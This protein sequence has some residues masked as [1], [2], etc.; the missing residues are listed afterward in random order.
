MQ[1]RIGL[2][3][4]FTTTLFSSACSED[5]TTAN[6][7]DGDEGSDEASN[8]DGQTGDD[9]DDVVTGSFDSGRRNDADSSVPKPPTDAS[10]SKDADDS[11]DEE[12]VESDGGSSPDASKPV[13]SGGSCLDGITDFGAKGPFK[14]AAKPSGRIKMWIPEVPA[15][16]KVP[17]IHLA[18]GTGA[19]CSSYQNVLNTLASHGFLTTC[20]E[21]TNTGAGSQ[22]LMALEAA[23]SMYPDLADK[24]F[25]TTGH[26][27]GGQAAFTVLA[28]AEEKF[29]AD[30]VYAG[31]AMQPASGFGDQPT[32][33]TWQQVYA[34]IKSPM[35][36][37][38]GT[39]DS[40]V[41]ASWVQRGFD[42]LDDG[43]EAYNWSARG[44]THIPTPQ[45]ETQEVA[46]PWFRWKLLGDQAA[47]QAFKALPGKGR[48]TE[49]KAQNAAECE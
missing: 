30:A 28:L 27:Q 22:G 8:D 39:S 34:K 12:A 16:C 24:R 21:D 23:V 35:F 43:I 41:S 1:I 2:V 3:C 17:V 26:S 19:S 38:S 40:L 31:L 10:S 45:A 32:G 6:P 42:A 36:A 49:V 11:V 15:G 48:W 13:T 33:G 44:S 47:C 18:N 46:V 14:Y 5:P 25:G 9:D 29:G 7:I 20:Y 37:F 4:F